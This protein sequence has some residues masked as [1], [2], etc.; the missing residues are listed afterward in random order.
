MHEYDAILLENHFFSALFICILF[1]II[2]VGWTYHLSEKETNI[3]PTYVANKFKITWTPRKKNLSEKISY[4]RCIVKTASFL[5]IPASYCWYEML[6][7]S[8]T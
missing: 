4:H 8:L 3:F 7:F 1:Y 5:F 2:P 6:I